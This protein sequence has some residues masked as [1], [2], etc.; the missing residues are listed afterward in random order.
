MGITI[1][2]VEMLVRRAGY[3]PIVGHG[4]VGVHLPAP[5]GVGLTLVQA[6]A[7]CRGAELGADGL[8]GQLALYQWGLPWLRSAL[9]AGLPS[10]SRQGARLNAD[11]IAEGLA[12]CLPWLRG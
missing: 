4:V 1:T 2:N 12:A 8:K 6:V 9:D 11:D 3:A 7:L 5:D 10:P